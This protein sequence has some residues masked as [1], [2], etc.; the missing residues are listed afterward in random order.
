MNNLLFYRHELS[1]HCH[2]VELFLSILGLNFTTIE[3]D[4]ALGEHRQADF[5]RK[6]SFGQVPVLIDGDTVL[7]DSNAILVYLARTYKKDSGWYPTDAEQSAQVQRFLSVA[8][9][10][11]ANGPAA[12]RLVT[13]FDAKLDYERA[14]DVAT[15]VLRDLEAHLA[16]RDWLVG[17]EPTIAD[18][19]I[20]SYIAHA[21]EGGIDLEV[22][23]NI[24]GWLSRIETLPGFVPMLKSTHSIPERIK[25]VR[26][27]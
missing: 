9:G 26:V 19:A 27:L 3:V 24:R 13:L 4:L 20:Y 18:L 5:L 2:R 1:G 8:S 23:S 14:K 25:G 15:G 6:N 17:T 7:A 21:P 22:Y 11:I 12:A 10:Q 16:G